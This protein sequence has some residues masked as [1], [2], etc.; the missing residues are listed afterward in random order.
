M[1]NFSFSAIDLSQDDIGRA[2]GNVL[3]P[4]DHVC[5]VTEAK[6]KQSKTGGHML[7]VKLSAEGTGGSITS[8]INLL[9]PTSTEATRIGREQL[10]AL[11]VHGGH[12]NPNRPGDVSSIRGL[13]VG[14]R[15][16]AEPYTAKDGS[17]KQGSK[18]TGFMPPSE[19]AGAPATAASS[20]RPAADL[21]DE[22]PF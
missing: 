6:M 3:P 12:R 4:G 17:V 15:V 13:R 20:I 11:L 10:K 22:I 16:V 19:V 1:S 7:E 18:V 2:G 5:R 8:Y 9:V 21:D 14:V